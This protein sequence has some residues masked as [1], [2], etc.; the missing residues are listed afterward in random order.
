MMMKEKMA[1]L[2]AKLFIK[3]TIDKTVIEP[4]IQI[5]HITF[6]TVGTLP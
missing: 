6:T 5:P 2:D 4:T 1:K 3:A